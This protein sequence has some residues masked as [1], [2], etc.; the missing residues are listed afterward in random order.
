EPGPRGTLALLPARAHRLERRTVTI[1]RR[2]LPDVLG[3]MKRAD[4]AQRRRHALSVLRTVARRVHAGDVRGPAAVGLE[5]PLAMLD[6]L[7]SGERRAGV[8][9]VGEERVGKT[10][11]VHEWLRSRGER[12]APL[13]F[14]TSG[15]Q[16][17]AGMSLLGQWQERV[18]RVMAAAE[19]LDAILWLDDLRDLL[20]DA[21]G[22]V[23]LAAAIKPWLDEG[24]VRVIGELTPEAA[25]L[26]ATRQAGLYAALM[27]LR[28][29]PQDARAGR[30]ALR[31]CIEHA[32][33]R[34]PHRARLHESAIDAIVELTDRFQPYRPFPGKAVRL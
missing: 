3:S 23:D 31:A 5:R 21:H 26:F 20:G 32:R 29:E 8:L 28:V 17:V 2:S 11:L 6:A 7:L 9:L 30:A 15:A 18:R 25:D 12:D 14:A 22:H 33:A 24:R 19:T 13:L 1:E 34:E 27:P 10:T 4:E 16:L